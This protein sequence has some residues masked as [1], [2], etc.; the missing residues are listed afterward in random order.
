MTTP[1][2]PPTQASLLTQPTH[3]RTATG[4]YAS[5]GITL[6]PHADLD[7][8]SDIVSADAVCAGNVDATVDV[9]VPV[10]GLA[11]LRGAWGDQPPRH[12][13]VRQ[14]DP[15]AGRPPSCSGPDSPDPDA[16]AVEGGLVAPMPGQVLMVD[17]RPGD[18]VAAGQVLVVIGGHEDGA[19]DHRPLSTARCARCELRLATKSTTESFWW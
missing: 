4:R 16:E 17:V 11:G 10:P 8:A 7:A 1:E 18:R 5:H 9:E 13:L 14:P 3:R 12:P 15:S 6:R 19:P 2:M